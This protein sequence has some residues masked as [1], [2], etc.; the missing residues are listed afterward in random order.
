MGRGVPSTAGWLAHRWVFAGGVR[1]PYWEFGH[2][3]A[4]V[5]I[6]G[7]EDGLLSRRGMAWALHWVA[8]WLA[9]GFRVVVLGRR[10]VVPPNFPVRQMAADA[11]AAIRELGVRPM[12]VVGLSAGGLVVRWMAA[13]FPQACR[14]VVLLSA[15]VDGRSSPE[16]ERFFDALARAARTGDWAG[17]LEQALSVYLTAPLRHRWRLG[18]ALLRRVGRPDSTERL[19]R[20]LQAFREALGDRVGRLALPV[21]AVGGGLD[22][23][24]PMGIGGP[25]P[26]EPVRPGGLRV[27][28]Q[29]WLAGA[30]SAVLQHHRVVARELARFLREIARAEPVWR[31]ALRA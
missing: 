27:R 24:V 14:A 23:M 8:R 4:L 1:V 16:F 28:R 3:P 15:P 18:L 10:E 12:A 17:A 31:P 29:V 19:L 25:G 26:G 11:V 22:P 6:P 20:H 7:L 2:G 30:H 5:Y 9:P 21:L 13:D